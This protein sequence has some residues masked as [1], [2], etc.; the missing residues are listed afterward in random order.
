M[1]I[2]HMLNNPGR[3]GRRGRATELPARGDA[4]L[5]EHLPQVPFDR[6]RADEQLRGDFWIAQAFT[7]H[8][9][10]LRFLSSQRVT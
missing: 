3:S 2:T 6:V 7:S 5:R 1:G 8:A 4:K 10:D 9:G